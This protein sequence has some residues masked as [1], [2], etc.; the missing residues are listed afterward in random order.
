MDANELLARIRRSLHRVNRGEPAP[1]PT[2]PALAAL[3]A[4]EAEVLAL[5][6]D[7]LTQAEIAAR[8][9]VSPRTV[10]THIQHILSKLDV[11]SRAQAVAMALRQGLR[12]GD[13]VAHF[14]GR[15]H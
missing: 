4:R 8:L 1:G 3:T 7:G 13:V 11:H 2:S 5:L 9:V 6:A 10:G 12:G 14:G 15:A